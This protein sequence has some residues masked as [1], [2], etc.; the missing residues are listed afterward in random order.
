MDGS[1]PQTGMSA[2]DRG[3]R[4]T[5]QEGFN[6]CLHIAPVSPSVPYT[7]SIFWSWLALFSLQQSRDQYRMK[8]FSQ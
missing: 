8:E 7:L 4:Q 6:Q 2:G 1:V 3:D 5:G